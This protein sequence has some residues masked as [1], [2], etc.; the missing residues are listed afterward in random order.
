M[1]LDTDKFDFVREKSTNWQ[2]E[3]EST[4]ALS[5]MLFEEF[6]SSTTPFAEVVGTRVIDIAKKCGI[7]S[8]NAL[9]IGCGTG[10][11][12]FAMASGFSKVCWRKKIVLRSN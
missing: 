3:S 9:H 1:L 12:T 7:Q 6:T 10:R 2:Y 8:G 11:A 5:K 4:A